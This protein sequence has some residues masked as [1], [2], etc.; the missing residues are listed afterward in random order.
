MTRTSERHPRPSKKPRRYCPK[1]VSLY[2]LTIHDVDRVIDVQEPYYGQL[3]CGDKV[4]EGRP[5]Y[6][7]YLITTYD[8][9]TKLN[10]VILS[11]GI[12]LWWGSRVKTCTRIL[13]RC[14]GR[15]PC[16][17]VY[18]ITIPG[19]YQERWTHITV[20]GGDYTK[21][22]L[23]DLGYCRSVLYVLKSSS[24]HNQTKFHNATD[25]PLVLIHYVLFLM[26]GRS[27]TLPVK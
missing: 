9:D 10:F 11:Q 24:H 22:L 16:K 8:E 14:Y 25:V 23:R 18:L 21:I 20:S 17:I 27:Y 6:P 1:R 7:S 5:N 19:M 13:T 15:K 12:P 4:V 2:N 26:H 3:K